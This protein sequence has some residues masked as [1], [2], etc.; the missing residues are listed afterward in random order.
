MKKGFTLIELIVLIGI[1]AIFASI[2]FGAF[3]RENG[4]VTFG[5]ETAYA[6]GFFSSCPSTPSDT[7][8]V[9]DTQKKLRTAVPLPQLT[10]SLERSN[11]SR[12]LTTFDDP[13]KISYIYLVS[14]GR[15]MAFYTV[16]GK[17]T[18]GSKRLTNPDRVID[19][20]GSLINLD[21]GDSWGC[22]ASVITVPSPE[23][24]GTY[25]SSADYIYFWTTDG[26]YVQWN[27]EYMLSDQALK[28]STQPELVRTIK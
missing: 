4:R 28:L 15:V 23:L 20:C 2:V 25:G 7:E 24:D 17:V 12:R 21:G 19:D 22:T 26:T 3:H 13:A 14:Y 6:C 5:P 10:N 9:A 16:K 18:S 1:I 27:G 11:I 8:A